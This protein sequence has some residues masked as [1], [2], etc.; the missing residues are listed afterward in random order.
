[1]GRSAMQDLI[2]AVLSSSSG[3]TDWRYRN[4]VGREQLRGLSEEQVAAWRQPFSMELDESQGIRSHEDDDGEF[5]FFWATKI[6]GPSHG[7]DFEAQC[8][9]PLLANARHKVILVSD[10]SYP[11]HPVGRAHFRLLWTHDGN[12]PVLWLE[13]VNQDFRANVDTRLYGVA[14]LE[15]AVEKSNLL[16]I[17]LSCMPHLEPQLAKVVGSAGSVR[18]VSERLVLRPSNGVLEAS[19]YL[20]PK[21]DWVQLEEETTEPIQRVVYQPAGKDVLVVSQN[22][23]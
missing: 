23:N 22:S 1:M 21:H 15:H 18:V 10:P 16:G 2:G 8:L 9:L 13:A 4:D 14:V 12:L 17:M 6:G 20:S 7:F 5:G 11:Y 19:D 3:F